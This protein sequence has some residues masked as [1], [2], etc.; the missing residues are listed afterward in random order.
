MPRYVV[1][2]VVMVPVFTT[3]TA[4]N[5]R[6]ARAIAQE[7]NKTPLFTPCARC[8]GNPQEPRSQWSPCEGSTAQLDENSLVIERQEKDD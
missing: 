7:G 5:K 1:Y 8:R 4:K 3:V 2:G 6:A